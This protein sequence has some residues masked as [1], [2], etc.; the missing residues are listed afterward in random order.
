M[1]DLIVQTV[2]LAQLLENG[3]PVQLV[4]AY[5]SLV[6]SNALVFSIGIL[7]PQYHSSFIEILVDSV[8]GDCS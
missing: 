3:I 2:A 8:Y 5:T 6:A 4:Y 1:V 7:M